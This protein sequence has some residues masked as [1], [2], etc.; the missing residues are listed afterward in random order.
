MDEIAK[1]LNESIEGSYI[2]AFKDPLVDLSQIALDELLK[3]DLLKEIPVVKTLLAIPATWRGISDYLLI[4]KI[5]EFLFQLNSIS[6]EEKSKFLKSLESHERE[7]I[8][9]QLVLVLEKHESYE[10]SKIQGKLF[11]ALIKNKLT[12][13]E[14]FAL[15]YALTM[16]NT[17]NLERLVNF[18]IKV[19]PG[20]SPEMDASLLYNFV[21]LQLIKVDN[22]SI[23]TWGGGGPQ[24]KHNELGKK[25]IDAI[26]D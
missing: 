19:Q 18:Y 7:K 13:I 20:T 21:F 17:D 9:G 6:S 8:I 5:L 15:T 11:K 25:F 10:K 22:S 12:N 23:G 4:K 24:F 26:Q 1:S 2:E 3:S 14:Y 16:L